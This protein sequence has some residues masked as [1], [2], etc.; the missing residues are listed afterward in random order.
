MQSFPVTVLD[1]FFD[2]PD[3]VRAWAL[4]QEYTSDPR[5]QW[6]GMRSKTIFELDESF[7]HVITRKV[8]SIFY[9]L[10]TEDVNWIV[11]ANFQIINKEYE[12]GWV[13]TDDAVSQIT[14]IIYLNPNANLNSGTSIYQQRKDLLQHN[15]AYLDKKRDSYLNKLSIQDARKYKEEHNSQYEETIRVNNVYNRLICFD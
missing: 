4:Q 2:D 1:N 10:S 12:S 7:F 9:D 8:F 15:H 3:K 14:G 5:G 6:P 11:N 13:H